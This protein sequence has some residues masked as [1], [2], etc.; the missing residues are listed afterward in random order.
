MIGKNNGTRRRGTASSAR[1]AG[2]PG[3]RAQVVRRNQTPSGVTSPFNIRE[4]DLRGG[5]SAGF[6]AWGG[7]R[8][9]F[10][11]FCVW[12]ISCVFWVILG[13]LVGF[14]LAFSRVLWYP[15]SVGGGR[16][17][18]AGALAGAGGRLGRCLFRPGLFF[19]FFVSVGVWVVRARAGCRSGGG[20][21]PSRP[22]SRSAV[23]AAPF[24][25]CGGWLFGAVGLGPPRFR[26][27]GRFP[28]PR[29][30]GGAGVGASL[31]SG[32]SFARSGSFLPLLSGGLF[33]P[34]AA[35][36][37]VPSAASGAVFSPRFVSVFFPASAAVA[38]SA[39]ASRWAPFCGV[40][41]V[42]WLPLLG[43]GPAFCVRVPLRAGG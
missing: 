16:G 43:V 25:R 36:V 38:A 19:S 33:P 12:V 31:L 5:R 1:P 3:A 27:R 32:G 42:R 35:V 14:S 24:S 20:S 6:L 40:L 28:R 15:V 13:Y 41:P 9:P 37:A 8:A 11:A 39:F 18:G 34:S 10:L 4:E 21:L 7:F 29:G 2:P 23:W 30:L 22:L 17:V 26:S